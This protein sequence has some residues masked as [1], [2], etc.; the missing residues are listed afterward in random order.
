[1]DVVKGIV[2]NSRH[3]TE[4]SMRSKYVSGRGYKTKGKTN[5]IAVFNVNLTPVEIRLPESI[6]VNDGDEVIVAGGKSRGVLTG[7]AYKNLT[8]RASGSSPVITYVIGGL[9]SSFIGSVL[10]Q[11][12]LPF[13]FPG[14][15]FA[16]AGYNFYIAI[17]NFR[18]TAIVNRGF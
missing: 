14:I 18:A 7:F 12:K 11:A 16:I 17:R 6:I 3:S 13:F 8:V 10:F 1:M 4:V 2:K 5:Q 15:L 9:F